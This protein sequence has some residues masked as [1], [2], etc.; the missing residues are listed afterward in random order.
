[1]VTISQRLAA[2]CDLIPAGT[3]VADIGTDHAHLPVY[4]AL[5]QTNPR[6]IATEISAGPFT[7]ALDSVLAAGVGD[8]VELRLG[9][10][11][12]VLTPDEVQVIVI[13]GMG[14]TT[15]TDILT[16][17]RSVL[18]GV[19]RL[20]LQPMGG[21]E[22]IRR[23]LEESGFTIVRENLVK[24]DNRFYEIIAAEPG[25]AR[26]ERDILHTVGPRLYAE[27]HP[28]LAEYLTGLTGHYE[29]ILGQMDGTESADVG[30]RRRE[31]AAKVVELREVI[32]CLQLCRI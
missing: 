26:V 4:L 31:L 1:M 30:Q 13:A 16:V 22:G 17:G 27:G 25:L 29:M 12:Q 8:R 14:A 6:I 9:D 2:I 24:E 19:T 32:R 20:I 11:L 15:I 21:G 28:L 3:T 10:G 5:R 7:R 18:T 23:W